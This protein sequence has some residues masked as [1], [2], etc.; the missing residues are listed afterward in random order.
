MPDERREPDDRSAVVTGVRRTAVR[1]NLETLAP[2]PSMP[3][4]DQPGAVLDYML[5]LAQMHR[6]DAAYAAARA[7][8]TATEVKGEL[9]DLKAHVIKQGGKLE[10]LEER[11]TMVANTQ[12]TQNSELVSQKQSIQKL[13]ETFEGIISN[14]TTRQDRHERA[15]EAR[16]ARQDRRMDD[17]ERT[18]AQFRELY[19][20]DIDVRRRQVALEETKNGHAPETPRAAQDDSGDPPT[21]IRPKGK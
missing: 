5:A 10:R 8:E 15:T 20:A 19:T 17:F 11:V 9:D 12:I 14:V 1:K 7:E 16:F 2:T 18:F 4:R 3:P 6:S 21:T 13:Q